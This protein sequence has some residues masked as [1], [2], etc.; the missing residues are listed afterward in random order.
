[1]SSDVFQENLMFI[2]LDFTC[3]NI[4]W[5]FCNQGRG[6]ERKLEIKADADSPKR[7]VIELSNMS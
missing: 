1:M 4:I 3:K 2:L 6:E 7:Q 5:Y